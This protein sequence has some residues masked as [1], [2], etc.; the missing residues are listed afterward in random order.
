MVIEF[1][2]YFINVSIAFNNIIFFQICNYNMIFK[3]LQLQNT[4]QNFKFLQLQHTQKIC[5]GLCDFSSIISYV[6]LQ[7]WMIDE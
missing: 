2:Q 3:M 1:H 6:R 7:S 4:I 5:F